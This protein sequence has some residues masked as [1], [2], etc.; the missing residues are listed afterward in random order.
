MLAHGARKIPHDEAFERGKAKFAPLID[1]LM[2]ISR[3]P[4]Q[5]V[6]Q[7]RGICACPRKRQMLAGAP[8]ERCKA[9]APE[10]RRRRAILAIERLIQQTLELLPFALIQLFEMERRHHARRPMSHCETPSTRRVT[11]GPERPS[12]PETEAASAASSSSRS[13]VS[14]RAREASAITAA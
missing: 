12:S 8:I 7:I 4:I 6:Q 13:T 9:F 14:V 10:L 1:D 2:R 11:S 3:Q 5:P